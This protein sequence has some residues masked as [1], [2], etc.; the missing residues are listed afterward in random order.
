[1]KPH[2]ATLLSAACEFMCLFE[3]CLVQFGHMFVNVMQ[4]VA[5]KT[6]AVSLSLTTLFWCPACWIVTRLVTMDACKVLRD[7]QESSMKAISYMLIML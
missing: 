5:S 3:P 7:L 2:Q 1:M 4:G 6:H